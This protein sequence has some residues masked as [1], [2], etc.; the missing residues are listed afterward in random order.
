MP[1]VQP[2][3]RGRR[4][5]CPQDIVLEH[6]IQT[7][8]LNLLAWHPKVAWAERFNVGAAV[9]DHP[10]RPRRYIRY[11][12]AGCSDIIGQLI[13]G[14]FLAVE[15]KR[16][17]AKA[18]ESQSTFLERV[19][20]NNGVAILAYSPEDVAKALQLAYTVTETA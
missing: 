12:F 10:G 14:R 11:A 13:D 19:H 6:D 16:P 15:V 3:T 7:A 8:I 17:G 18:T 5:I 2:T 4:V 9:I 1:R 20:Q